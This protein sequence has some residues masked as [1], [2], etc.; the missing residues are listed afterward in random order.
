ML[1]FQQKHLNKTIEKIVFLN[2]KIKELEILKMKTQFNC[3]KNMYNKS[4]LLV[5]LQPLLY[6]NVDFGW[7][8][9]MPL[10]CQPDL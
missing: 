3:E 9:P 8:N 4:I 6:V 1:G 2:N 10:L 7:V 5:I